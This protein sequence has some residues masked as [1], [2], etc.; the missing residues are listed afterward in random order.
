[1]ESIRCAVNHYNSYREWVAEQITSLLKL[2]KVLKVTI[3]KGGYS[4]F[5]PVFLGKSFN[6]NE[7]LDEYVAQKRMVVLGEYHGAPP[8]F[9]C[10]LASRKRWRSLEISKVLFGC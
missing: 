1:V 10:K 9:N 4:T 7:F 6:L 8:S 3:G 5:S 2:N